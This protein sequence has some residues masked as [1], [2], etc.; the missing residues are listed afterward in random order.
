[1]E[2]QAKSVKELSK[3]RMCIGAVIFGLGWGLAGLNV[4]VYLIHSALF[5]LSVVI[6][7]GGFLILGSLIVETI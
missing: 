1:M 7:F 2:N 4:A 3:K 6:I 5:T